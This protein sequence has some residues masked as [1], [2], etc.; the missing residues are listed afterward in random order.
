MAASCKSG[1]GLHG[2]GPFF[3]QGRPLSGP[4]FLRELRPGSGRWSQ[5]PMTWAQQYQCQ[6]RCCG[7]HTTLAR[8][9][10]QKCTL[11]LVKWVDYSAFCAEP[12]GCS[13]CSWTC[14]TMSSSRP[15]S[16]RG[17]S[18]GWLTPSRCSVCALTMWLAGG[19]QAALAAL[20]RCGRLKL[21]SHGRCGAVVSPFTSTLSNHITGCKASHPCWA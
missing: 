1:L 20:L 5:P 10:A 18:P 17:C 4:C 14:K 8:I 11:P 15:S 21:A 19:Q 7:L 3:F 13:A 9:Q 16:R 12:A 2:K 6:P